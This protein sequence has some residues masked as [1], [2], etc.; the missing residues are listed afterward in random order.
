VAIPAAAL[1]KQFEEIYLPEESEPI[2]LPR[3]SPALHLV[4]RIRDEA[5]RFAVSYHRALRGKGQ[6]ASALDELPGVGPAR[7]KALIATFGSAAAA[8]RATVEELR[9][10]PGIS[11][12]LARTIHEALAREEG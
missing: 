2:L 1:A 10:V 9:S 11:A 12:S 3:N 6:T 5:H 7:K 4:Q 8:K